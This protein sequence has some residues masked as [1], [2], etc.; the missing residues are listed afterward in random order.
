[1]KVV[2][3]RVYNCKYAHKHCPQNFSFY[4]QWYRCSRQD[5]RRAH[6]L[7]FFS[8][9]CSTYK[10]TVLKKGRQEL[11]ASRLKAAERLTS[12]LTIISDWG[13][14]NLVSFNDSETQFLH[15]STW[16]NLPNN[17]PLLF[18][19]TQ[20]S[21]SSTIHI[22]GLYQFQ[23]LN[24]K[25]HSSFLTKSASL[26]L[27]VL[28]C[29]GQIFFPSQLLSTYEGLV[30]PHM[31]YASHMWGGSTHVSSGQSGVKGSLSL[32]WVY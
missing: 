6:R 3:V 21:P 17:Y 19:N 2:L 7:H 22:L 26:R 31:E 23:N 29:L 20:L 28:Y 32:F 8:N 13:K 12:D 15:L 27:G 18:N 11:Q 9:W 14:R 10:L 25:L 1:M 5:S 24:W 16:H 30:C 4:V